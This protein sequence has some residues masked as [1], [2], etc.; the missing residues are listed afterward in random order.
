MATA[1]ITMAGVAALSNDMSHVVYSSAKPL[2]SGERLELE[3][4]YGQW[5]VKSAIAVCPLGDIEC[6]ER[7]AKRLSET[8][9]RRR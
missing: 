3:K 2:E 8:R 1:L 6:V 5:A 4:K 7:E 9:L